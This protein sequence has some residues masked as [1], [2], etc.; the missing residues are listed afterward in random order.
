MAQEALDQ[1]AR[2]WTNLQSKRFN[3]RSRKTAFV[4]TGKQ[5]SVLSRPS[6]P[7]S[8]RPQRTLPQASA[9]ACTQNCQ[10]SRRHVESQVPVCRD[11]PF[12]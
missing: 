8:P 5:P 12:A 4:D 10:R 7:R 9:R 3:D 6:Q 1:K 11:E 2:K